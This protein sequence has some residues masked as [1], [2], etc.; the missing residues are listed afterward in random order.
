M[1]GPSRA[2]LRRLG[3]CAGVLLGLLGLGQRTLAD[4]DSSSGPFVFAL[5]GDPQIG[6]GRGGEYADAG[7][8]ARVIESVNG[9][10]LP[11][12]VVA[13]D[14]VQDRSIWQDWAFDLMLS[15]LAGRVLLVAGNHDVVDPSSLASYRARHGRDY[16]DVVF[17][18]TAF[19]VLNSETARDRGISSDEYDAQWAFLETSLVAHRRAKRDHIL[20]AM[21][22]PPFVED[23]HEPDSAQNW[24]AAPRARLLS[25]SRAHGVRVI[26]AGHLHRT[27]TASTHDGIEVVVS[28]GSARSFDRSPIAYYRF[29]VAPGGLRHE[30]V[31]VAKAPPEPFSVPGLRDWTPRL[32]EF[33]LR[34]WLFTLLYALSGWFALGAARA[35]RTR[36]KDAPS[37]RLWFAIAGLLFFY[38]TNMQLDF[39]ELIR[40]IGRVAAQITGV[41]AVRHV[42]TAGSACVVAGASAVLLIRLY[43]RSQRDRALPITLAMLAIPTAWWALSVISHHTLGML[44][45]EM[46]WD[47]SI[48]VA[49]AV[50]GALARRTA[51]RV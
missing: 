37:Q 22:R 13:G 49:L 24:P 50:I 7:R 30:L 36:E 48:L 25:L 43:L 34:H 45:N 18:N 20:L 12:S 2:Q 9:S 26:L 39:D 8:F 35:L 51:K 10:G 31:S 16:Y 17:H 1:K 28:A 27:V 19:V 33:S 6:Y 42:I 4:G 44:F 32:F 21:H 46:W 5:L 40:E 11:L 41:F 38:A 29:H 15:R 23:E 47:L 14:L 3:C